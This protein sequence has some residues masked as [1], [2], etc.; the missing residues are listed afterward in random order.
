[1]GKG[2]SCICFP[3][4]RVRGN[5]KPARTTPKIQEFATSFS[6]A[7]NAAR[8]APTL[9]GKGVTT[10]EGRGWEKGGGVGG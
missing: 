2:E 7:G 3:S 5:L 8:K 4:E 9:V 10:G 1:M 6:H